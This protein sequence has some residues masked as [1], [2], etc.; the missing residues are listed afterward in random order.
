MLKLT[1][2]EVALAVAFAFLGFV[3]TSR[4]WILF[5]N[6]LSPVQGLIVYYMI[7]YA[8]LYVLS[9]LDLVVFGFRIKEPLQTFGLLLLTFSFF[10]ITDW[11][12]P[13][14]QFA[15]G[16]TVENVSPVLFQAEDGA[17][18]F[19]WQSAMPWLDVEALRILTYVLTPFILGLVGG[20][21]VS[22]KPRIG[23]P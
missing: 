9:R 4:N 23:A 1:F 18:W 12:S 14:I 16:R 19:L 17:V 7:L 3:F 5:L 15:T 11:E 13:Y 2:H 10:L 20:W 21:L 6:E 8:S 22:R